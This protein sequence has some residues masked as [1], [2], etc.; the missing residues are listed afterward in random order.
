MITRI[1]ILLISAMFIVPTA[2]AQPGANSSR[3]G[4]EILRQDEKPKT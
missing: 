3:A 1:L 4:G 2:S